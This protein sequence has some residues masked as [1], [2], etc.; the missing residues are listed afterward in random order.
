MKPSARASARAT[1]LLPAPA[2]P[3]IATTIR[4]RLLPPACASQAMSAARS[5]LEARVGHRRRV[6]PQH[7]DALRSGQAGHRAEHRQPVIAVRVD[8]A[9]RERRA[10]PAD[11]E[12]VRRLLDVRAEATEGRSPR[13]RD[14]VG[15]LVPE[16]LGA[17]AP[18]SPRRR[19]RRAGPPAS[20]RRWPAEPR[21]A[22]PRWPRATTRP[23]RAPPPARVGPRRRRPRARPRSP[24]PSAR[25]S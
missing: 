24:R 4:E 23:R 1:V 3:S 13:C 25:R 5:G 22:P 12:A 18:R 6:H 15:L 9:A 16:L 7:F 19:T 14:P 20:A 2:G 17:R 11:R 21:P 8:R 10:V